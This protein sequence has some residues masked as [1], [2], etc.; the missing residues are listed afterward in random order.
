MPKFERECRYLVAKIKD[1]D[2]ALSADKQAEF[3]ALHEKISQHRIEM[4]KPV[5]ECVVIENDWPE[6]DDVWR[7]I[8]NRVE[9]K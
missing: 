4:G 6:Y 7:S 2:A 3:A 8:Q 1:I 5:L 9:Q